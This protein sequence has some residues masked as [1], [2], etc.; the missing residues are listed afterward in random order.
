VFCV[1][2]NSES[3]TRFS[4]FVNIC[5]WRYYLFFFYILINNKM[6]TKRVAWWQRAWDLHS[7]S[8]V[9]VRVCIS[10][11]SLGQP[12]FYSLTWAYKVRFPG[13]GVSSNPK[14]KWPQISQNHKNQHYRRGIFLSFFLYG[15]IIHM[16]LSLKKLTL[17]IRGDGVF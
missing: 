17:G 2:G 8:W 4:I 11:K 15:K 14:T 13:G 10:C 5:I 3:P 12:R 1:W 6:T 9:R 7:K 16:P